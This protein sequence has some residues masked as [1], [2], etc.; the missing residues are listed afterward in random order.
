MPLLSLRSCSPQP[1]R[2]A[3]RAAQAAKRALKN[4]ALAFLAALKDEGVTQQLLQRFGGATCMTDRT[5]A[6]ACLI[7]TPG[8]SPVPSWAH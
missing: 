6:L 5:A 7:D 2:H 4:K 3:G 1:P 8:V